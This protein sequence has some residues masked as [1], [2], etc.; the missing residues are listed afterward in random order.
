MCA[1]YDDDTWE[2][3]VFVGVGEV[4]EDN[5]QEE[6]EEEEDEEEEDEEGTLPQPLRFK[7]AIRILEDVQCLLDHRGCVKEATQVN[8]L[9]NDL[10]SLNSLHLKQDSLLNYFGIQQ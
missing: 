8:V 4:T 1:E 7:E 2:N 9:V 3:S 10:A 5:E 6:D